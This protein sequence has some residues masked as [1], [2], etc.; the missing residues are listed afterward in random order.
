MDGWEDAI[1]AAASVAAV[2]FAVMGFRGLIEG[3]EGFSGRCDDCH[4]ATLLPP[5]ISHRCW[6]CRHSGSAVQSAQR[7]LGVQSDTVG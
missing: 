2:F 4:R 6:R 3:V 5:P 1:V 7:E